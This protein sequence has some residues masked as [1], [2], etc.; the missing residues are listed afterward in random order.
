MEH[1]EKEGRDL[2]SGE[3]TCDANATFL[4]TYFFFEGESERFCFS[5]FRTCVFF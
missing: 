2:G 4:L 1:P 3:E 5:W